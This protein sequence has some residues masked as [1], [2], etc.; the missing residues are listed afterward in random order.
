MAAAKTQSVTL[1]A[2]EVASRIV[3][4]LAKDVLGLKERP[5]SIDEEIGQRFFVR[6]EARILTRLP[7]MGSILGAEFLVAVGDIRAFERADRLAAYAGLWSRRPVTP[8]NGWATTKGC[9]VA[10]RASSGSST[11]RPSPACVVHRSPELS[12]IARERKVRGTLRP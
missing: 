12:T 8:A 1:P 4:E 9:V 11:S 7:G 5:E 3:A 2:Q 10:T 6:P